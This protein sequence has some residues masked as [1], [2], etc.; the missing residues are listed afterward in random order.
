VHG[1]A[2]Y[3]TASRRLWASPDAGRSWRRLTTPCTWTGTYGAALAAWSPTDLGLVCGSQP[4]AGNQAKTFYAS[5]DGG[6]HWRLT[7]QIAFTAGYVTSLAA[8]S[9]NRWALAEARDDLSMGTN[10][11]QTWRPAIF[12]AH[13][14][15]VEG[16]RYVA[17][18]DRTHAVA[19]PWTLN[20]DVLAFSADGAHSWREVSFA[21]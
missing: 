11:G 21:R 3:L 16:W 8:A 17:F 9:L 15:V 5:I 6:A 1:A 4:A 2:I 14:P 12:P 20:G 19:V 18:T 7:A 13:A 10:G